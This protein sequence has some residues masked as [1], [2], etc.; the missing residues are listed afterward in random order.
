[1]CNK[2]DIV[3]LVELF[4]AAFPNYRPDEKATL[5]A[6]YSLLQDIPSEELQMAAR[7]CIAE[8]GRAFA[9][10]IG[11]LRGK[12]IEIAIQAAGVPTPWEAWEMITNARSQRYF[13]NCDQALAIKGRQPTNTSNYWA[14]INEL[15]QHSQTCKECGWRIAGTPTP[16]IVELVARRLGWP[17]KF[18]GNEIEMDRA[19]FIRAYED[20]VRRATEQ[21][22]A[23]A[24]VRAYIAG[25][26]GSAGQAIKA[27]AEGK[28]A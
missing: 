24:D 23:P 27:L 8:P 28:R 12:V 25:G 15:D 20:A 11:E 7:A 10:S 17:E 13:H 3:N 1:M 16:E 6:L 9:P 4:R 18:P 14:I 19:H 22:S 2:L 5:P 21:V 26:A